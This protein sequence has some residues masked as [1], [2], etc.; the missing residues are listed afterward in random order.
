[1]ILSSRNSMDKEQHELEIQN[2]FRSQT[3]GSNGL[4]SIINN[5]GFKNRCI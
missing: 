1:M 2:P 4:S 3:N 5:F